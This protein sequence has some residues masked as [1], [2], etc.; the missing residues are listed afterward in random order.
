MLKAY[1]YRLYP[2]VDQCDKIDK[3]ISVCRLVYNLALEVKIRAW[4]SAR[5]NLSAFDLHKQLPELRKS[6]KWIADVDSHSLKAAILNLDRAFRGFYKGMGYPKFKKKQSYGAFQSPWN[7]REVNFTN[8]TLTIPKI[9][10][11]PI[12]ISRQFIGIIKTVTITKT[13]TGKYFA[14]ILVDDGIVCPK[15]PDISSTK[16]IGIDV[17]I[18][19]YV[20]TSDG[21]QFEPNRQ[22]KNSLNRLKCLQRRAAKKQKGSN[23]CKKAN[24]CVSILHEK[25]V[26]QRT[27]YIHKMTTQLIRDNQTESFVIEK[28]NVAGMLKNDKLS[29][30]ISDVSFGKLFEVLKYKCEWYGKN[31]ITIDQ[32]APS[33]KRC[34]CC[35]SI[36]KSLTLSQREWTCSDC[37][38]HHDRDYNAAK[39]ILWYGL[40]S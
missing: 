11:I 9:P 37:T 3:T 1:K 6:F 25:I 26:N 4:Q 20:V 28:L 7:K 12:K 24:K 10:N 23:N 18:N 33:S 36:N 35:G 22:L 8:S 30:A 27:D 13:P 40:N 19:S 34:S 21:R 29:Q 2:N 32:F 16:S 39:N 17:G 38:T 31:L 5:K 15:K 14:S